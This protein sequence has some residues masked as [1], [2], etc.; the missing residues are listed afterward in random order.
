MAGTTKRKLF[1]KFLDTKT[2]CDW[3]GL[4]IKLVLVVRAQRSG[5]KRALTKL[6]RYSKEIRKG[7][8]LT[9]RAF[10]RKLRKALN[11]SI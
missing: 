4:G 2:L 10:H 8:K 6:K 11:F 7:F 9:C 1:L 5:W 3:I